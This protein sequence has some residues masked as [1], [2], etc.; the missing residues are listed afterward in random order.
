MTGTK[1]VQI[2]GKKGTVPPVNFR[3]KQFKTPE[4]LSLALCG[5]FWGGKPFWVI[6]VPFHKFDQKKLFPSNKNISS[7]FFP[8]SNLLRKNNFRVIIEQSLFWPKRSFLSIS[9]KM[10]QNTRKTYL[11]VCGFLWGKTFSVLFV[12]FHWFDQKCCFLQ[13]KNF[14]RIFP[15]SN[16]LWKNNFLSFS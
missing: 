8:F 10:L 16:L 12:P 4:K 9:A 14:L 3:E 13:I 11:A 15:F 1:K 5:S 7:G 2:S 6:F